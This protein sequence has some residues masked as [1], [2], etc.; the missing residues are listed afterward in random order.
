ML[1]QLQLWDERAADWG[2]RISAR[3]RRLS[4]RVLCDGRV[5]VIAPPRTSARTVNDF[6]AAHR[7]WIERQQLRRAPLRTPFPPPNL[8]LS[9][10]GELWR[11]DSAAGPGPAHVIA[12]APGVLRLVGDLANTVRLRHKLMRWL[13]E[14]AHERLDASLRLLAQSMRVEVQRLQLRWQRTRWGS[15]SRHGTIS[16]NGCLLFQPPEVLRYLMVHEL[17]HLQHMNHSPRFWHC[18]ARYEPDW[19]RL[20]AELL[21]GWRRVPSWLLAA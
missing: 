17:A 4:V 20:D 3:A 21:Q 18:V 11:C 16:L 1:R 14:H 13:T 10:I 9:A 8:Q 7:G 6:V 2:V 5:E 15:C 12:A 19:K